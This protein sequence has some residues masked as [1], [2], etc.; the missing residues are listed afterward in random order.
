MHLWDHQT[1]CKILTMRLRRPH[2]NTV[3][4][5]VKTIGTY[6]IDNVFFG[7]TDAITRDCIDF[8]NYKTKEMEQLSLAKPRGFKDVMEV[9]QR[10]LL[11][12]EAV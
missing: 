10:S 12:R 3:S 9:I 1:S 8:A 4:D 7:K 6:A 11:N 5:Q 2:L